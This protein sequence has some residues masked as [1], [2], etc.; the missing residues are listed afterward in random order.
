MQA[1]SIPDTEALSCRT[2]Q[3]HCQRIR[4]HARITVTLGNLSRQ[5]GAD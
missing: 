4:L 2:G 5:A 3:I 1:A